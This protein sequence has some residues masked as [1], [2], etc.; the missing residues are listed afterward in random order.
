MY[1][2]SDVCSSD[3]TLDLA[4]FLLHII[5]R[6]AVVDRDTGR[7]GVVRTVFFDIVADD[8]DPA[9]PLCLNL[10]R[11]FIE[12]DIAFDALSAGHGDRVV[13]KYLVGARKRYVLGRS[14]YVGEDLGVR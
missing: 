13:D 4:K 14:V 11:Q 12:A 5:Q 3:L 6:V 9:D 1:W 8:R 7:E 2:S 10:A